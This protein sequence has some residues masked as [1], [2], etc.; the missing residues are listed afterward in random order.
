MCEGD[1]K[2]T[3]HIYIYKENYQYNCMISICTNTQGRNSKIHAGI[4]S[5]Q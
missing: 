2:D 5:G 1:D 3:Q 4:V